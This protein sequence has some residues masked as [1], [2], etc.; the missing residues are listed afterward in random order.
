[1]S[2]AKVLDIHLFNASTHHYRIN[3]DAVNGVVISSNT[4]STEFNA[5]VPFFGDDVR[6]IN[7]EPITGIACLGNQHPMAVVRDMTRVASWDSQK[8]REYS[9]FTIGD[10]LITTDKNIYFAVNGDLIER[11]K[12]EGLS[13][14][15]G[16]A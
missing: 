14:G 9:M 15:R 3:V 7:K 13:Q 6:T 10:L 1:M 11:T 8:L 16:I 5:H 2:E 4:E 12:V